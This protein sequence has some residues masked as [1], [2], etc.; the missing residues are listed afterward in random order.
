MS[1]PRRRRHKSRQQ[2]NANNARTVV[3]VECGSRGAAG[4]VH[5]PGGDPENGEGHARESASSY[6]ER[7]SNRIAGMDL[8]PNAIQYLANEITQTRIYGSLPTATY[9]RLIQQLADRSGL[10]S[11]A[12]IQEAEY[13]VYGPGDDN[14]DYDDPMAWY[15]QAEHEKHLA[16][17]AA[18][19]RYRRNS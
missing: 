3:C 17:Q 11:T 1:Q 14:D 7:M 18:R 6:E 13:Q 9:F 16:D 5:Y 10:R 8:S 12:L 2:Q 4:V 19:H 15:D